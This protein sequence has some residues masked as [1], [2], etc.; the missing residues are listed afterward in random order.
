V[1]IAA[2]RDAALAGV[3]ERRHPLNKPLDVLAQHVVTV[4]AGDGFYAD[5]LYQEVRSTLAYNDLSKQEWD[6]ILD[7]AAKGGPALRVYPQ[8][9][10]VVREGERY[11]VA[12]ERV[13]RKHRIMIGTITSDESIPVRYRN[14]RQLGTLEAGFIAKLR[15]G[16][17]FSFAGRSLELVGVREAVAL[18][19]RAPTTSVMV[20]RWK[21]GRMPLSTELA[22]SVRSK[23]LEARNGVYHDPEMMSVRP[24]LRLQEAW[25]AIPGEGELL[26]EELKTRE[27]HHLFFF[28]F[29]GRLVHEGL[30]SLIAFRIS[31]TL[32]I[33]FAFSVNDYGIELLSPS[34]IPFRSALDSG[35]LALRGLSKDIRECVNASGMAKFQFRQIAR[36]SGLVFPGYPGQRK[37]VKQQQIGSNLLYDVFAR[38]DPENLLLAQAEQEVLEGQ[39]E[40][41]RLRA[42]LAAINRSRIVFTQ[43][44]GLTPFAFP[45]LASRLAHRL[46]SEQLSKRIERMVL[47]LETAAGG[48]S[49][50]P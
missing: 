28:P 31:R 13:A 33:S 1:E 7:F 21:G 16:D 5:R 30:A 23:L 8:Y 36:V 17:Q 3:I 11:L 24:I 38:Y 39:L 48:V 50:E 25:S 2:A 41:S 40:L 47:K 27:G 19:R 6:W 4:A 15:E 37:R 18:V 34:P 32:P 12:Q 22:N 43:P 20:P 49:D 10:K 35:L 46:S 42:A 45:L 44:P 26:V 9:Q 14:G 29:E